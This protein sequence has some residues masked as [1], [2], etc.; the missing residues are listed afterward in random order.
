MIKLVVSLML[1]GFF[2]PAYA[3]DNMS[4]V[5]PA[6]SSNWD[7]QKTEILGAPEMVFFDKRVIVKAPPFAEDSSNVP[8]LVDAT[9]LSDVRRMVLLVDFGPIPKILTY[10]PGL[11]E[12][13][14]SFR[15]K[16]DQATPIRAA[17]ET[18][19]GIWHIGT[20]YVDAGGGGC[21]APAHAY[22]TSDWSERL[23][24]V[25][26]LIW[27]DAGRVRVVIDHPMDTGLADGIPKFI[28]DKLQLEN[29]DGTRM[30]RMELHE[31]VNEDPAFTFYFPS[32]RLKES[33]RIYGKDN[34]GNEFDAVLQSHLT[35]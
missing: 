16:I 31:P 2:F 30:A 25:S 32:N 12:A 33:I 13:K 29:V 14:L 1:T 26:G 28:I 20:T 5:D 21:T 24:E 15:F 34:N 8:V 11:A 18:D 7:Y 27:P 35:Q 9:A 10:W 23:G 17:V 22:T 6:K 4:L 3:D 19:D